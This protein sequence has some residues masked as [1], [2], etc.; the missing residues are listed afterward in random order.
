MTTRVG[1]VTRA[2]SASIALRTEC[3]RVAYTRQGRASTTSRSRIG[4]CHGASHSVS[5]SQRPN[6]PRRVRAAGS[7]PGAAHNV[8]TTAPVE[9]AAAVRA[10]LASSLRKVA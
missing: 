2:A 6:C 3:E 7:V 4:A 9:V 8:A 1:A 10:L 5:T